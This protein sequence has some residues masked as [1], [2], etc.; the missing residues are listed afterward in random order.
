MTRL[1]AS[2]LVLCASLV[3]GGCPN[4]QAPATP[5]PAPAPTAP[6]PTTAPAPATGEHGTAANDWCGGHGVPESICT[7]CNESLIAGFK[8]KKDWCA[9]H[10]LPESQ[11]LTCNPELKAKFEAMAP[12]R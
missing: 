10:N 8:E 3:L 2:G 12:K 5:P 7:R 1:F 11:C 9:E 6:A 4:S